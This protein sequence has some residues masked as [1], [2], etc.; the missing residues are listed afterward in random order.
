VGTRFPFGIFE[1]WSFLPVEAEVL[2]YPAVG[3]IPGRIIPTSDE[4][5]HAGAAKVLTKAGHDEFW[6]IREFREGD[7]PRHIHW[8]SAARLGKRMVKE[9]HREESQNVCLLLDAHVPEGEDALRE[10]FE[11]AVSF[12]ATLSRDLLA[13]DY[14]VSFA[15]YGQSMVKLPTDRGARQ[16][17]QVLTALA[18]I[19]PSAGADFEAMLR[20]LDPRI[21]GD[22]F[23][24]AVMLDASRERDARAL[25][26]RSWNQRLRIL[27]VDSPAFRV[28]FEPPAE[29]RP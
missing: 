7:N 16:G 23:I 14:G 13:Q 18:E 4:Y 3:R 20:E 8:R 11:R 29:G 25:L 5:R 9:F 6:G 10:R 12:V 24:V 26:A 15:A 17:R 21:T 19:Q 2:V 28:L 22:A 1:K 27:S